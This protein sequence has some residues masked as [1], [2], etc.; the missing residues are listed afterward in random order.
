MRTT[1]RQRYTMAEIAVNTMVSPTFP[2][3]LTAHEVLQRGPMATYDSLCYLQDAHPDCTFS[4]VIGSDWL[5]AD[6]DLREWESADG[7]TGHR[8]ISEFDFLVLRRPGFDVEELGFFGPRMRWLE[9]PHGFTLIQS[10]YSSTE[11]RMIRS[12]SAPDQH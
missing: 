3:K 11:V 1:P 6:T 10:T 7:R 2:I 12:C 9:L 5:Q 4:W 8:L